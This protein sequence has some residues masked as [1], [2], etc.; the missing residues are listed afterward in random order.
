MVADTAAGDGAGG[1][2]GKSV[3]A[4]AGA[5]EFSTDWATAKGEAEGAPGSDGAV[6]DFITAKG[7]PPDVG[8]AAKGE[9]DKAGPATDGGAK[10]D[11]TAWGI[12]GGRGSPAAGEV[13][14]GLLPE[15]TRGGIEAEPAA[16]GDAAVNGEG[17]M[18][19]AN[20]FPSGVGEDTGTNGP[21]SAPT[22]EA[23]IMGAEDSNIPLT[24]ASGSVISMSSSGRGGRWNNSGQAS[25]IWDSLRTG[26]PACIDSR[27]G[28][29]GSGT[30]WSGLMP[31]NRSKAAG[32][33]AAISRAVICRP[34]TAENGPVGPP[35]KLLRTPWPRGGAGGPAS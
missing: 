11:T 9:G 26:R 1:G 23:G 24:L 20:G 27:S 30:G 19:E 18:R 17:A 22:A 4:G 32:S 5:S 8:V 3:G 25:W 2:G 34:D 33:K 15:G 31:S 35:C 16:N 10:G 13:A 29:K 12:D 14:N 6:A 7:D 28:P 21:V